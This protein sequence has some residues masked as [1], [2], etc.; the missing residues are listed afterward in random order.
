MPDPESAVCEFY[1]VSKDESYISRRGHFNEP[2]NV[3]I[4]LIRILG[5]AGGFHAVEMLIS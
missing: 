4:F 3:A 2:G 1:K 5:A